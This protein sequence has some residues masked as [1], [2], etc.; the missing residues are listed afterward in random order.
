MWSIK[1][2][3]Q[4][5]I[6]ELFLIYEARINVFVV[7]QHCPYADISSLDKIAIHIFKIEQGQIQAYCRLIPETHK[8]KLGRVLVNEAY[9]QLGL[10]RQIVDKAL[11]YCQENYPN[12]PIF[13]QAQAYLENFYMIFGFKAI[14]E[15]YLEDNIPHID[16]LKEA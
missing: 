13:A 15:C 1:H 16:M 10:G 6:D 3:S 11:D 12:L 8:I 4:L 9:R 14:S 7:E 5:T 2:F